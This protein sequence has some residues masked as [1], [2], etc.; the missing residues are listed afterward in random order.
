VHPAKLLGHPAN[1]ERIIALP[2]RL[3]LEELSFETILKDTFFENFSEEPSFERR[4]CDSGRT[5]EYVPE[6]R[7]LECFRKKRLPEGNLL[8]EEGSSGNYFF[9]F[10]NACFL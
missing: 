6:E 3:F 4:W 5:P 7:V 8:P 1:S 10:K 2:R 9:Y